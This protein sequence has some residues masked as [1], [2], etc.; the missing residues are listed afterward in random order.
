VQGNLHS[1]HLEDG[2][3]TPPLSPARQPRADF[4]LSPQ[5]VNATTAASQKGS[6]TGRS[7]RS[8]HDA[9]PVS[10][11]ERLAN[12]RP[13]SSGPARGRIPEPR[14]QTAR[15]LLRRRR[16]TPAVWR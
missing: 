5:A 7:R 1:D 12:S 4:R 14:Q 10:D 15:D 3:A 8:A 13:D 11:A 2:P 6:T 16:G 9:G